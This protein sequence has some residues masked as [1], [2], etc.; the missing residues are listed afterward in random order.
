MPPY[1]CPV[2]GGKGSVPPGF[3]DTGGY[4][5]DTTTNINIRQPCRACGGSGV[6]VTPDEY[7]PPVVTVT[8]GNT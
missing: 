6:I 8:D 4:P 2:C 5:W 1:I 7:Q 3:Y